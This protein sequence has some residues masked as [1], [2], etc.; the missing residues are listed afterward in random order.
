M[1]DPK[2]IRNEL[3][4]V[5]KRLKVKNFELN[6]EQLKEWEGAR[7]DL[8]LDTEKLQNERNSKSKLIGE[9]KSQGKDVS[10]ILTDMEDLKSSLDKKKNELVE[11]QSKLHEYLL[12]VPNIPDDEVPP[13]KDESDNQVINTWGSCLKYNFDVKDHS[14]L[15]ENWNKDWI[16]QQPLLFRVLDLLCSKG[17]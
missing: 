1:L 14:E 8:Q 12:N 3:G 10:A 5:A 2:L 7:K 16:L 4:V 15:G 17:D 6:V 11:I 13:G 9:A